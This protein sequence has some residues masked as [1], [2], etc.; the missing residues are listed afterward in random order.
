MLNTPADAY[1]HLTPTQ[2]ADDPNKKS[3]LLLLLVIIIII[4]IIIV[5]LYSP[6]IQL[7]AQ[8]RFYE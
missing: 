1:I 8:E 5:Y 2:A 4:I 7:P 6:S 3:T